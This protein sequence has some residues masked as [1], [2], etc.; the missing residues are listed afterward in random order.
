MPARSAT[1]MGVH[2]FFLE[3]NERLLTADIGWEK[4]ESLFKRG[5]IKIGI[6]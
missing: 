6:F 4:I 5:C 1:E 3:N 2:F